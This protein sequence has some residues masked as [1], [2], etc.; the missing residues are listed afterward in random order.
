LAK[1]IFES[2]HIRLLQRRI[3][4]VDS[5]IDHIVYDLYE[6]TEEEIKVVEGG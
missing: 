3:A 4:A 5:E 1:E 6:L 2:D